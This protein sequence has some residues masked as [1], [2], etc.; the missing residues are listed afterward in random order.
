MELVLGWNFTITQAWVYA[1]K[2]Y[3]LFWNFKIKN[4]SQGCK[5]S[6]N[7]EL[8]WTYR[9]VPSYDVIFAP[10]TISIVPILIYYDYISKL[11]PSWLVTLIC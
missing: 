10:Y 1:T 9:H 4:S 11:N 5:L 8:T 3:I 7:I 2:F 6:L